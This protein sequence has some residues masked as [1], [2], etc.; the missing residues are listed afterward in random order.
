M[1]TS[2]HIRIFQVLSAAPFRAWANAPGVQGAYRPKG[3]LAAAFT[4]HHRRGAEKVMEQLSKDVF[5]QLGQALGVDGHLRDK[6][7]SY[8]SP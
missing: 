1:A 2:P 8:P 3:D 4:R 6:I 7:R 5:T